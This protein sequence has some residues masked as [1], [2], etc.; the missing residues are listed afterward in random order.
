MKRAVPTGRTTTQDLYAAVALELGVS[1]A[2]AR[3]AVNS[4]FSVV[5]RALMKGHPVN[6]TNFGTLTPGQRQAPVGIPGEDFVRVHFRTSPSL[7]QAMRYG[8]SMTFRVDKLP[9]DYLR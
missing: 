8:D 1:K 4:V 6:V 3:E 2:K 7:Q 9:K 5:A